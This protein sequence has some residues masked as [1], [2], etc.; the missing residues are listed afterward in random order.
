VRWALPVWLICLLTE[1]LPDNRIAI[2]LRGALLRPFIA[3]AGKGLRVGR[4]VTLLNTDRLE[5][6]DDVWIS[7]GAWV[8]ALGRVYIEDEVLVGPYV[9]ISSLRHEFRDGSARFGGTSAAPVRIGRG[10]WL[11]SHVSVSMGADVGAGSVV[12]ANSSVS[13]AIRSGVVAVGVPARVISERS[14]APSDV[15]SRSDLLGL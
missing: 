7:H 14:D 11:A 15:R 1:V 10:A 8:N 9:T 5:L 12:A 3:R 4:G 2:T 6:G 13:K